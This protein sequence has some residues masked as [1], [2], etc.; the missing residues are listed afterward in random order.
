MQRRLSTADL[1]RLRTALRRKAIDPTK[2]LFGPDSATW[3][4]NREP[5]LLLG[6]GRALLMQLAHPLVAAG[7]AE[8]SGF[9]EQP[10]QRLRQ[11]L[12]LMLTIVFADGA[13]ALRAVREIERVHKRV[14]GILAE[15]IGPF[16]RGT[17]YAAGDPALLFW[18]HATLLDSALLVYE[19]F[20]GPLKPALR[21]AHYEESKVVARLFAIPEHFI[22]RTLTE[23]RDYM[24]HMLAGDTLTVGRAAREVA[25]AILSPPLPPG[26][27][28]AFQMTNFFTIGLLPP[29]LRHRYSLAWGTQRQ[30][31][32]ESIQTMSGTVLPFL[33]SILRSLPYAHRGTAVGSPAHTR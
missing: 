4:I 28:Q 7:V 26:L 22:P 14:R 24:R 32:L 1:D 12:D 18:V 6:G 17:R 21:R 15:D 27:K 3:R 25:A 23:F 19:R 29:V 13:S 9:R 20:V 5:I 2:T 8:H 33:P 31:L 16:P 30:W 11:T 10:L